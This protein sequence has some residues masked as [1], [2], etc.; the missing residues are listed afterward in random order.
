MVVVDSGS[1]RERRYLGGPFAT[2]VGQLPEAGQ[3]LGVGDG[4]Q[5]VVI[6]DQ[7]GLYTVHGSQVMRWLS[8][9]GAGSVE[10]G[11]PE[12]F[13]IGDSL[14]LG[15]QFAITEAMPDWTLTYDGENGRGSASGVSIA[16]ALGA[17]GHDVVVIELGTND[18]SV[19]AFR[20]NARSILTSLQS[21]PLV[22]WQT[23]KGPEDVVP[24]DELNATIHQLI[25]ARPGVA[26]ADW[27]GRVRDEELSFDGVH[28]LAGSEDAMARLLSPMLTRWWSAVTADQV[29][30]A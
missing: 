3:V 14:L 23:V 9:P 30:C 1:A 18:R 25:A 22:L 21:V 27:A 5:A 28:P 6:P 8:L 29:R 20:D 10:P 17:S 7:E 2:K 26:L 16:E 12:A 4:T 19:E 15:G 13:M 11:G 24:A